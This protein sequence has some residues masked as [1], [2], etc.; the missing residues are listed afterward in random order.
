MTVNLIVTLKSGAALIGATPFGRVLVKV[1]VI[2]AVWECPRR[3]RNAN[4]TVVF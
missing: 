3:L 1:T 2:F 4:L